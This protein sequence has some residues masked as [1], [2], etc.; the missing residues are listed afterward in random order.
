MDPMGNIDRGLEI[1]LG[2][3]LLVQKDVH[4]VNKTVCQALQTTDQ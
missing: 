3:S 1:P 4:K 2:Y